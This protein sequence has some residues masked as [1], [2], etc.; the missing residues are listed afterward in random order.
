[1]ELAAVGLGARLRH[2]PPQLSGGEQQRVAIA[3]ALAPRPALLFADEPTGN[4]DHATGLA[5]ADL[6]FA[7]AAEAG[8]ALVMVTH[9]EALARRCGRIVRLSDGLIASDQSA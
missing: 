8:A 3:R 9:D 4:L 6:L 2:Y 7:R 5:V 1:A